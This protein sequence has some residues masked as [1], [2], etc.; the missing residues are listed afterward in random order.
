MLKWDFVAFILNIISIRKHMAEWMLSMTLRVHDKVL[1]HVWSYNF[2]DMTL[3]FNV[4][5]HMINIRGGIKK[6]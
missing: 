6:F 3:S 2:N 4:Q 1:L 5:S